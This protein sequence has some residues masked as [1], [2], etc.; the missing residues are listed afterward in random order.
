MSAGTPRPE[1]RRPP[2][3]LVVS[4]IPSHPADQGNAARI[5]ALGAA[6]MA[7]GVICDF[8]YYAT[9][10]LIPPQQAAMA[11]FWHAL[12]IVP[13][14]PVGR[15][16]H[17]G[18]WGIDDWCAPA[19]VGQVAA[20]QRGWRYDAVL[21]NYVWMSAVLEAV[22]DALRLLDTHDLF[23]DRHLAA[24][25]LGVDP[26][27]FFTTVAEEARG[28]DRADLVLAIQAEEA[29]VLRTRTVKPVLTLGHMPPLE[30][31][32]RDAAAPPRHPFGY[33]GSANPW[34]AASVLALDAA[35][36]EAP[37][38]WLIAGRILGRQD[39]VLASRPARMADVPD[40][41]QFYA[42]VDCVLNPMTGGTGLKIKTVEALAH[43]R[44]VLGTSA[45]F[46]GLPAEH[47]GH[48]APDV[49]A[50]VGLMHEYAGSPAF[51]HDLRRASRLLA[52]RHAAAVAA[53]QDSL[54]ARL[55]ALV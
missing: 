26:S 17:P 34:N 14:V 29:A 2:R 39:L 10:G 42:A 18:C 48:C 22:P 16:R 51:R 54:A 21:V 6:L 49:P 25:A 3:L 35:L 28:L 9:E 7:R 15:M 5:Q 52:L 44:P 20:L 38:P 45:A 32:M 13:P 46:A 41:A 11:G 53:E 27:W 40:P 36:R 47:P 12:H 31:L 50:L 8:L 33:L 30:F 43:G 24:H 4:P 55:H 37:L 19:L 1:S 23:G